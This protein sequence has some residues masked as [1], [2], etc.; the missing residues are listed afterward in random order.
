MLSTGLQARPG[1]QSDFSPE[2][3]WVRYRNSREV[4]GT[5]KNVTV[6]R[7]GDKWYVS[8]QTEREIEV[9]K[10]PANSAIGI[11]MGVVRFATLSDGS[12]IEPLNSFKNHE[13]KL[14]CEQRR[15][16]RKAKFSN[17]WHRQKRKITRLHQR[18]ANVRAD[19]LHKTSTAISKNHA[20]VV[21]ED[22]QIKNMSASAKGSLEQPGRNVNQKRGLNRSIL[23]QGWGEFRRQLE[24]KQIWRGGLVLA[25]PPQNTSRTCPECG[26]VSADNRKTQARF[27]CVACGHS[28]NADLVAAI[29]I[30]SAGH[31]VSAC[32]EMVQSGRSVK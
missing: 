2:G 32:G 8:I 3:C 15:L 25:V 12:F 23:D 5:V 29:N 10:H 18:I 22:L 24:Y 30:L 1:E 9:P 7:S 26:H 13:R 20:I 11:D 17:N 4:L 19:F 28:E 21:L 27:K 6:S 14:A 31:A 16:A